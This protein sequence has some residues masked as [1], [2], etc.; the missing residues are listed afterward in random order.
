M[1]E[2]GGAI[3]LTHGTLR[4]LRGIIVFG[5]L[6]GGL[7]VQAEERIFYY[8]A[9]RG[10]VS[11]KMKTALDD[12]AVQKVL[13][14]V[15]GRPRSEEYL[16]SAL[17][18]ARI[19]P[20]TLVDLGL[21]RRQGNL[22]AID[23][24]LFSHADEARMREITESHA[25]IL[26]TAILKRRTEIEAIM[27]EYRLP[28]VDP[29][30]VLYMS[31]GCFSLDWDGLAFTEERGY[32]SSPSLWERLFPRTLIFAWQPPGLSRREFY[33]GSHN[34]PYGK[35]T[36]TSF[37]DHEIQPRHTF[38]DLLWGQDGYPDPLKRRMKDLI[39]RKGEQTVGKQVAGL[40]TALRN[41]AR[42]LSDLAGAVGDSEQD[43]GKLA[44][45]L[46]E[47]LYLSR[48]DGKYS[49]RIPVF[50]ARDASMIQKIR[51]I[52]REEMERWFE[53]GYPQLHHEL[54]ELSPFRYGVSQEDFFYETWHDIFG[55]DN[56]ILV[57]SG[58]F[59]DPYS[60]RYG[61]KGVIPMVFESSV[62]DRP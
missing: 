56:R 60:E 32:R 13:L 46:V 9:I 5:C 6:L 19:A 45:L 61:A 1:D 11:S 58:L 57:E 50:T 16:K 15:A 41:G 25:R 27:N 23:F 2:Q 54:A 29:H 10:S 8:N 7:L 40:M 37:G 52:G 38:P 30:A 17:Q 26:A 62:Y 14:D 18:A 43:V 35:A 24:Y 34:T 51:K 33:K 49:S 59:A 47:L 53:S 3:K 4:L 12:I 55:A 31:L 39:G 28:G 36:L 20:G 42:G 22:Y 44:D 21:I 48:E